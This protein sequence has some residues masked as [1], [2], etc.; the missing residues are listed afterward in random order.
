MWAGLALSVCY[1]N[2]NPKHAFRRNH[3]GD[4]LCRYEE[5][6][7]MMKDAA[8]DSQDSKPLPGV[9]LE[10]LD[11]TTVHAYRQR[12]K[13]SH[14]GYAWNEADDEEVL[15]CIGAAA[16]I[17][18]GTTHPTDAGLLMFGHDWRISEVMPNYFLD[19]RQQFDSMMRW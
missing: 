19:Y 16:R 6:L 11:T 13:L 10:E 14:E 8:D 9:G 12:Y 5:V 18:D 15:R 7:S 17:E 2:D 3:A 4:Y 1:L